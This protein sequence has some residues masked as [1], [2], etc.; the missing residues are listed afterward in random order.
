MSEP[1]SVGPEKTIPAKKPV[2]PARNIIGLIVLVG[3]LVFGWFEYSAKRGFNAAVTA[4]EARTQDEDKGLMTVSGSREH[5][6][7]RKP[8]VRRSIS[9]RAS[10][11]STRRR[12]PGKGC[13][14]ITH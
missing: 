10:G 2:S 7:A 5:S 8:M 14:R 3:V 12:T 11:T 4:L 9:R 6:S 1:S 13:S